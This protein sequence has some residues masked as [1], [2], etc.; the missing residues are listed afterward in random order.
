M[1]IWKC[2]KNKFLQDHNF[3]FMLLSLRRDDSFDITV[4]DYMAHQRMHLHGLI[5]KYTWEYYKFR[6]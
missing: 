4:R 6:N 2:I 5:L 1:V 3:R